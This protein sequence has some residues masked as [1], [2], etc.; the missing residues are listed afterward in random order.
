M[1]ALSFLT[2]GSHEQ[3]VYVTHRAA[4]A[5]RV[6][7]LPAGLPPALAAALAA[8]GHHRAVQP[9]AP[10]LGPAL[11]GPQRGGLD[12]H[13]QRQVALVHAAHARRLRPR[14]AQ[15]GALSLPHQGARPGPGPQARRPAPA[16][17]GRRPLRRRHA[18]VPS[19]RASAP[20]P[21]S[22]CR[23][24]TCCTS[25]SCPPTSA[26]PSSCITCATS[27]STR[28]TS[29]AACSARTSPRSCAGCAGC[30]RPTARRPSSCSPRRRSP[31]RSPSPSGSSACP[32]PPSTRTARRSPSRRSCSGT[33][34]FSTSLWACARARS[35]SPATCS[36][37]RSSRGRRAIDFA[38]TRKAAELI[39]GYTRRRL[40]DR[41]PRA[42]EAVMPYRAGYTPAA[43]AR[44]RA[45]P[46]RRRAA[47]RGR[48][49]RAR[50]RHRRRQPRRLAGHRLSRHD[51]E[52]L[53]A[54][55]ARGPR[56]QGL[57]GAGRRPGRPRPV[58]H[59]RARAPALAR[60]R[61]GDRRSRQPAHPR[62]APRARPPTSS[63]STERDE[64]YF[65]DAGMA[66]AA[67]LAAGGKLRRS[68]RRRPR[69]VAGPTPRPRG[70]SLRSR[71]GRDVRHRRRPRRHGAGHRR[72][73]ARL[74]L[75]APR[76][77][78]PAPR[79]ELPRART[80]TST[81]AT[82]AGRADFAAPTTRRPRSR[83]TC[84]S[85]APRRRARSP[86]APCL[87]FG[88]IEVTEQVVAYQKRDLDGDEVIDTVTLDLPEQVFTHRGALVHPAAGA[89]RRPRRRGRGA[90]RPARAPSTPASPFCPSTRCAT[91]GTSA[92]CRPPGTGRPTWPP[93]SS[94]TAT[95]AASA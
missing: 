64:T 74:S 27:C 78:L 93:S 95:R 69:L 43:A 81:R 28:P 25:A 39:Y 75:G 2:D 47:R 29:T 31:T 30:A 14:P 22:C 87:V 77:R 91:A 15:H 72:A 51:D 50:A 24:P 1:A 3:V 38:P 70:S 53:A 16:R 73:R 94:T 26:G 62:R 13:R 35:P 48:H 44:H 83:S 49:Q 76:G 68:A 86:P 8:P 55:G 36:P 5:A 32:S 7:P 80:S 82:V 20:A 33:R 65:G 11:R 54:L 17:R 42:A 66:R 67:Q 46:V 88:T 21:P 85:P 9:P 90:R 60:G 45:P 79:R 92:A 34:R 56:R 52:P 89:A 41:D 57:G 40:E 4:R 18:A 6:E 63:R 10:R 59:A 37:R 84:S 12:R 61:G 23:T 58:L 71:L 19:A